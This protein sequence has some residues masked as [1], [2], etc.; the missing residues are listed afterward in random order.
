MR[1]ALL[2]TPST[3]HTARWTG[4][5][6]TGRGHD[7]SAPI[8]VADVRSAGAL[9]HE[10]ADS[11]RGSRLPDVVLALGWEAGLA[12]QVATRNH[13]VPVVLRL[14]R[15]G[16]EP[17]SDH[18]RLEMALARSSALVL[19][20]S[21]GERDRLAD[22]GVG[23]DRLGILPDAVERARFP[24]DGTAAASTRLRVAVPMTSAAG[25]ADDTVLRAVPAGCEPVAVHL[26]QAEDLLASRL[27]SC[28]ALVV[29]DDSEADVALS[30]RAMSCAVPVVAVDRGVLSD[31]VA[32]EVTGVLVRPGRLPAAL[33]SLLADRTRREA[34]GL[35]AVDRVR[36]RFTPDVVGEALERALLELR[37]VGRDP[38]RADRRSVAVAS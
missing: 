20:P 27:R 18:F 32:D 1:V 28:A 17:G 21:V 33:Q 15:V 4:P 14:G 5:S 12:A 9:G 34:M 6:L 29:A 35:A 10:L 11:W 30:L 26:G 31:V 22:C 23:R 36:A 19:V 25:A 24:D 7:V 37:S 2:C 8:L 38:D 16:R 3:G 13:R